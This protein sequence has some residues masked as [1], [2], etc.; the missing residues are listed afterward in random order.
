MNEKCSRGGVN[1]EE[2]YREN[3]TL[4]ASPWRRW[5]Q[6]GGDLRVL[7]ENALTALICSCGAE[8]VM[9]EVSNLKAASQRIVVPLIEGLKSRA[10]S[11]KSNYRRNVSVSTKP[12]VSSL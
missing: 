8:V 10:L 5:L 3:I 12:S 6:D 4:Y 2:E 1:D 7:A 11:E 9:R